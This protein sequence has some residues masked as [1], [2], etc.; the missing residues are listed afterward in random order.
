M[1]AQQAASKT[2]SVEGMDTGSI[3]PGTKIIKSQKQWLKTFQ[4]EIMNLLNMK[5]VSICNWSPDMIKNPLSFTV[6]KSRHGRTLKTKAKELETYITQK[7]VKCQNWK[8]WIQRIQFNKYKPDEQ[9]L[10]YIGWILE[11]M[12]CNRFKQWQFLVNVLLFSGTLFTTLF[13]TW[14]CLVFF[15]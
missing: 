4:K 12:G 13:T 7:H 1:A 11:K 15:I 10:H 2:A 14:K 3:P 6:K 9:L 5:A 8:V